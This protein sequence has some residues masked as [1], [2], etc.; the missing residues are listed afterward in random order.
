M[1]K[2]YDAAISHYIAEKKEALAVL[3]IYLNESVGV[4]DHS[5]FL[6]EIKKWTE[7]LS[8]AEECLTILENLK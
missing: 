4:S 5:N 3:D 1:N 8:Q 2:L 6:D 7:K